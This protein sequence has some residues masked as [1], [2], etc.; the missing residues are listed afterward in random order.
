MELDRRTS[1][2]IGAGQSGP[3]LHAADGTQLATRCWLASRPA[4]AIVVVSHGFTANKDDPNV[5]ALAG[6]LHGVGFDVITYDSRGHGQSGGLCTLGKHENQDVAAVV[7]WA[8]ARTPRVVLVG[9]SM[10]AVGVLSYAATDPALAGVITVSSPGHWRLPLRV[11]SLLTAGLARTA[12]GRRWARR[13]MNVRI[14]PW[15]S[16]DS[17][18]AHLGD[19]QCPVVVIHGDRDPII[20]W[21][22]SLANVVVEGSRRQLVL[23]PTMGHAFDPV[24]LGWICRAATRLVRD[25]AGDAVARCSPSETDEVPIRQQAHAG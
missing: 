17:A 14:A 10:G 16:P 22:A 18:P 5:V 3:V 13:T 1:A 19:V 15:G 8:R 23:V 25:A 7:A 24:G 2:T 6:R 9:A 21:N 4:D 11:P 20:P 12:P